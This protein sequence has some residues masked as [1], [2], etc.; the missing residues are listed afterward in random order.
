MGTFTLAHAEL[1]KLCTMGA[2]KTQI[3]GLILSTSSCTSVSWDRVESLPG[4][5]NEPNM[6]LGSWAALKLP[7]PLVWPQL[8]RGTQPPWGPPVWAGPSKGESLKTGR[9]TKTK[10]ISASAQISPPTPGSMT[11]LDLL[12]R[13]ILLSFIRQRKLAESFR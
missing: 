9:V 4:R 6:T 1:H 7:R 2:K 11:Y 12:L 10:L 13:T 3:A 8:L 5:V